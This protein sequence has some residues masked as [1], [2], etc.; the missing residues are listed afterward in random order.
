M[1][2]PVY[3]MCDPADI[4]PATHVCLHPVYVQAPQLIPPL[5]MAGGIA[6]SIAILGVWA[7]AAVYRN[8]SK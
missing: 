6:I 1:A 2:V 5:D 7:L 4:D 8:V 3:M